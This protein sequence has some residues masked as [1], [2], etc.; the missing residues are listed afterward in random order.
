MSL[1]LVGF[2]SAWTPAK[3]GAL[4]GVLQTSDGTFV[5]L[6]TPRIANFP[7]A[8]TLILE[9]Q[10]EFRPDST[11]VMID[12]PTIV[13]N[14]AGQRPV[15]NII[16]SAVNRRYGGMQPASTAKT[17]MFGDAAPV[18]PF[19]TRFGGPA[20]PAGLASDTRV[21]ETYPVLVMIALD[22]MMP[23][24][25]TAGRLPKYNPGRRKTFSQSDW[26]HVATLTRDAYRQRKLP[27]ITEWLE[28]RVGGAPPRK[29][30]QDGLDACLCLLVALY[31]AEGRECLMIGNLLSGY[32]VVPHSEVLA[33]ELEARCVTTGR[34]PSDWVRAFQLK[35]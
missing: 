18:W 24:A 7:G 19:L 14:A 20:D 29:S 10:L 23:D 21:I 1:L 12:Q 35:R 27:A 4:A 5:E 13:A 3:S 30:D 22:W 28:A 16:A 31:L 11:I 33:T 25:R 17:E 26:L 9:W 15:E 34:E 2:D 6:G 8:E 32:I